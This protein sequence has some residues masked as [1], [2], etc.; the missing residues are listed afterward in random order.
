MKPKKEQVAQRIIHIKEILGLSL[1][2]LAE[3]VGVP[4]GTFNS[5][6][7]G[8][9]VP[10]ESVVKKLSEISSYP[11][12]WIYYGE[13]ID[14]LKDL[15]STSGYEKFIND[16][17][18]ILNDLKE[19]LSDEYVEK[20]PHGVYVI[21]IFKNKFYYPK[22]EKYVEGL[23]VDFVQIVNE[24]PIKEGDKILKADKY[25][26]NVWMSL[27]MNFE[28][29]DDEKVLTV[30]KNEFER[31][32]ELYNHFNSNKEAKYEDFLI[33]LVQDLS[34]KEKTKNLINNISK[35][36]VGEDLATDELIEIFKLMK[37]HIEKIIN[38]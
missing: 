31:W 26:K 4:K 36:T 30:A 21:N 8:L 22:M 14:Y 18:Y 25:L 29:G 28:Y 6:T 15:L 23:I 17:P 11:I 5:Y 7:R 38:N 32:N 27:G 9:A 35:I 16:F 24:R 20:Y 34:D 2:K 12:D 19:E 3:I 37:P 13:L 10:P 1:A 33:N